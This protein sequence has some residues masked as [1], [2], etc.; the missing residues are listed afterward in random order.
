M[1]YLNLLLNDLRSPQFL[2]SEPTDRATWL[3]LL[4]FCADQENG[5]RI[6][7]CGKWADRKLQQLIG[8]TAEEIG[9]NSPLWEMDG[10]NLVV[11]RYPADKER[12]IQAKREAGRTYGRGMNRNRNRNGIGIT[13][14]AEANCS[15]NSSAIALSRE[16]LDAISKATGRKLIATVKTTAPHLRKLLK[17]GVAEDEIRA[18]VQWLCNGNQQREY[19]FAVLSGKALFEKWD[20][21]QA[22]MNKKQ[23]EGSKHD[24][25]IEV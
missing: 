5:G 17:A 23:T 25:F 11:W 3:C 12:E 6:E 16:M 2:G 22:A 18:A 21:I 8:V 9:R 24:D 20:R 19:P 10:D 1:N 15:A 4:A 14:G 7:G 13:R